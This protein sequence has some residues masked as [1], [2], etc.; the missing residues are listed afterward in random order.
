MTKTR[1]STP[2]L[3]VALLAFTFLVLTADSA[4][5]QGADEVLE[6]SRRAYAEAGPF[7]ETL[8]LELQMPDATRAARRQDY[9][10]GSQGDAFFRLTSNG[11]AALRI[12]ATQGR[13]I[14]V[15]TH[16]P[17][18]YAEI[19]AEGDFVAALDALEAPQ[20][21][22]WAPPA[23]VA[24]QGGDSLAFLE[25]LRF[26]VL[27][28]V[29]PVAVQEV[30]GAQGERILEVEL[31]GTNGMAILG[32]NAAS[33]RFATVR[34]ALGEGENQVR[35]TGIFTFVAGE[36]TDELTRPD[37]AGLVS[38]A[39]IT[40]L[41]AS[42]YPLGEAAPTITLQALEGEPVDLGAL[43]GQV[44]VLDF[45]ATWCVPCWSALEHTE[46]L[47]QWARGSGLPVKVF[48]VDSLERSGDLEAQ[49]LQAQSFLASKDLELDVLVDHDG[50]AFAAFHNPGL[51]SLVIVD[52]EGRLAKYHSGVLEEMTEA[53]KAQVQELLGPAE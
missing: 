22:L 21:Q 7:H 11:Q 6:R 13:A 9:G 48:A 43:A 16:I 25:A 35:A 23:I 10:V 19:A 45:W 38:V 47:T 40:A 53:V 36:P 3:A 15:W 51:P 30:R 50:K 14:A 27:E 2:H 44:I 33:G 26:G 52:R 8:E 18:R 41:E 17:G 34:F 29:E 32:I 42:E 39:T 12:V 5:A 46:A 24:A 20:V 4:A 31:E 1:P 37:V 28:P 49:R